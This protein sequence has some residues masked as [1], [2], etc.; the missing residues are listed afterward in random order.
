MKSIFPKDFITTQE[1]SMEALESVMQLAERMKLERQA[2]Y[3]HDHLLRARTLWSIFY[4]PSTR[5]RASFMA[6]MT[7][8][9]GETHTLNPSA[10]QSSIGEVIQDTGGVLATY[11]DAISVRYCF[12]KW[13][14]IP[15][16]HVRLWRIG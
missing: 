8:L 10:L 1:W 5:T 16:I 2:G 11:G 12:T 9:G 7:Q 3:Y 13:N 6:A 14:V 15:I 4:N